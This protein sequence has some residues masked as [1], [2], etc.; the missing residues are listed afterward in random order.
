M[1]KHIVFNSIFVLNFLILLVAC[2][3]KVQA[4]QYFFENYNVKQGLGHTKVKSIIQTSD[5]FIWI[6]TQS[7]LSKFDGERFT[8]FNVEDG[9]APLGVSVVYTDSN[10]AIWVGHFSGGLSVYR[11]KKFQQIVLKKVKGDITDIKVDKN[12]RLYIATLESGVYC[13]DDPNA[14]IIHVDT[15]LNESNGLSNNVFSM[16]NSPSL[17]MLFVTRY[18][19]KYLNSKTNKYEFVNE[20]F[21]NWPQYFSIIKVHEDNKGGF[22]VGTYN[23]GLYYY[24][25]IN[26]IPKIYD[27]RDG[28]ASNWVSEIFTDQYHRTWVGTHGGGISLFHEGKITTFNEANGLIDDKINCITSDREGNVLIGTYS[29]G[30]LIFKGFAFRNYY[31]MS[32]NKPVQIQS[33][34]SVDNEYWFGSNV[35]VY[36][37]KVENE[38]V[39]SLKTIV[40]DDIDLQSNDIRFIK[41]DKLGNMWIGTWGG[42]VSY[43]SVKAKR[44]KLALDLTNMIMMSTNSANVTAM[45]ID[46]KDHV[47]VGTYDGLLYYEPESGRLERLT[48]SSGLV[49]NDISALYYD[50]EGVL[51][52]GHREKGLTK[53]KGSDVKPYSFGV[54]ITPTAIFGNEASLWVGTEGMGLYLVKNKTIKSHFTLENGL[55]SNLISG[56]ALDKIGNLIIGTN[57]GLNVYNLKT[58]DLQ[59]FDANTGFIG[60]EVKPSAVYIDSKGLIWCGTSA[61]VTEINTKLLTI[62]K[63]E[64]I[65]LITRLRVNLQ[66]VEMTDQL[67]FSYTQ[68]SILIDF[69]SICISDASKVAYKVRLLG[70]QNEWQPSTNQTYANFPAL[71]P[72]DYVFEVMAQNNNGIWNKVPQQ[73][74]FT[75]RPPFWQTLWFYTLAALVLIISIVIFVKVRERQLKQEKA[76]LEQKVKE[77]TIEISHKN[78]L[79]AQ[80]NKDITD[81]INY[82]QRIQR[83]VLPPHDTMAKVLSAF[84]VFYRPKDIVSGDFHWN[85]FYKQRLI[86]AAADCTG[87]GVPGAFMSMISISSLNKVVKEKQITDPAEILNHMRTDIIT[88]LKQSGDTQSKDGLDIA[89]LSIDPK[90]RNVKFAGAYNSLYIVKSHEVDESKIDFE[91]GYSVFQNRLIEVKADR[92]PI[93]VSERMNIPFTTKELQLEEGDCL[94]IS[95]DGYIDQFGGA[96]GKK[97]MSKRFKELLLQLPQKMGEESN[98]ILDNQLIKWRGSIEQIDDVL[99]IGIRL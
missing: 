78:E 7:G 59:F 92:M 52:V 32:N 79:L 83:A 41:K 12:G 72:G 87:H 77:R 19:V 22:W 74:K 26:A 13:I 30:L 6:G 1:K 5:G 36:I 95:T 15:I 24:S 55:R 99:V 34:A 54:N 40:K 53:I 9:I 62:N 80:K 43:Y 17:G 48:Q 51:W 46:G 21:F 63:L 64:P 33:I 98:Q 94:Y 82:A 42:G 27:Q 60:V 68:N 81:S 86:V 96:D 10:E 39:S 97:L 47:W 31:Q 44:M 25:D 75:I 16:S 84:H 23:G 49:N 3:L 20:M 90:T 70:A 2:G 73:L 8:N 50:S 67:V 88:D 69:K 45:E 14:K 38:K 66:D 71:P 37:A 57:N 58:N 89:L 61:G 85:T 76:E 91:F 18:G 35:G 29:K 28:L 11:N 93:G 4:Q 65:T 56:L